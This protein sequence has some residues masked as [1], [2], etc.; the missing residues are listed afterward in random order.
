MS[1]LA[2]GR[3]AVWLQRRLG[4]CPTPEHHRRWTRRELLWKSVQ[5]CCCHFP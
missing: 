2:H 3:E 5:C 4:E 1:E